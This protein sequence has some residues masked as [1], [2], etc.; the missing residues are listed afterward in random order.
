VLT[1]LFIGPID[2]KLGRKK[3]MILGVVVAIAGK[4]WFLIDPFAV[5]AIYLNTFTVGFSV[6]VAFI[7]FNTNRNN[8]V[9]IIEWKDGRRLDSLVSTADNLISKLAAAGATELVA[10]LLSVTGYNADLTVQPPAAVGA[11]NFLLGW[12]PVIVSVVMLLAV[13]FLNIEDDMAR[14]N[15][16]KAGASYAP[17]KNFR[18][19]NHRGDDT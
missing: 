18:R 15:R 16:E 10:I 5:G 13:F 9:D 7:I 11:I 4:I 8:I 17:S 3:T 1:T 12:A 19:L 6:A 14:M 2:R